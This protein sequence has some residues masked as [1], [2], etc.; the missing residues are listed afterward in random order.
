MIKKL[1]RILSKGSKGKEDVEIKDM[2]GANLART[3]DTYAEAAALAQ[4]GLQHEA[5]EVLRRE[6][7]ERPKILVVGREDSFSRPLV[8]YAVG[9]A[10][11][12]GYEIVALN[13][14]PLGQEA[15]KILEPFKDEIRKKFKSNAVEGVELLA[16]RAEEEG[17]PWRHVVK[18][19]SPDQCIKE[20]HEELRRVEFVLTEPETSPR[21]G[22]E[23]SIPVFCLAR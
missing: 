20:L 23:P 6:V 11:R 17:V 15:P 12:M 8:D 9:F 2:K 18:F 16:S 10:R 19:G 7:A 1:K 5:R 21:E 14:V 4:G 3:L 22:T 13:C